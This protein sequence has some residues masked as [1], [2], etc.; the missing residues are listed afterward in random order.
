M[1][2]DRYR[3]LQQMRGQ[4]LDFPNRTPNIQL[5]GDNNRTVLT[6][7]IIGLFSIPI[8]SAIILSHVS[9]LGPDCSSPAPML[10]DLIL[11][12]L[13]LRH[14]VMKWWEKSGRG[15]EAGVE[16]KTLLRK[17]KTTNTPYSCNWMS[18]ELCQI[19]KYSNCGKTLGDE[20]IKGHNRHDYKYLT[21]STNSRNFG[22]RHEPTGGCVV[23]GHLHHTASS[24]LSD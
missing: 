6:V 12:T 9:G 4:Q 5:F 18:V 13:C 16:P 24:H 3:M 19:E 7:T 23:K 20:G 2:F 17:R 1:C 14:S 22:A 10:C 21:V 8:G 11:I 15:G